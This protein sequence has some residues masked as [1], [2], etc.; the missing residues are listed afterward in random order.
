MGRKPHDYEQA[1]TKKEK[2][3][4]A[5]LQRIKDA[6]KKS[7]LLK[8]VV[9]LTKKEEIFEVYDGNKLVE[10]VKVT[11]WTDTANNL[12]VD[13]LNEAAK[14]KRAPVRQKQMD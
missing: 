7:E 8:I 4:K 10:R 13:T 1:I 14:L 12:A 11:S 2:F 5:K 6:K 9:P 3:E